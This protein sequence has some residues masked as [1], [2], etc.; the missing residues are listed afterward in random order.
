MKKQLMTATAAA[1]LA[2]AGA[3][4]TASAEIP[5][6]I[7]AGYGYWFFDRDVNGFDVDDT[8]TPVV[9]LE[10]AF[11]DNWAAEI[12]F[13]D[14]ETDLDGGP[15]ADVTT[16]QVGVLYYAGSYIGDGMRLRPYAAF[17]AGEIDIDA[18]TFDT[19]ETTVNGGLG[20][21][22]ML[23]KRVGVRLEAR[24]LYSLDESETD[25]LTTAG[26]NIYL[27]KVDADPVVQE[28]LDS[29]G[30]GVP[31]D[32]D[33]CPGTAPGT[34]VDADGCPLPVAK[35][36]SVKLKVN[37]DF[38][39]TKVKEQYFSDLGELADFLKRFSDLQVDVEGHTDSVGSDDYNLGLSQ[40]RA[41]AVVDVLVNQYG[42]ERSRLEPKGYGEAQPVASNDTK[43]G[44][45]EN[46]RV[47]ATLEVEYDD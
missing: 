20:V 23:G 16:W 30:D 43:E 6:T 35:V 39:S 29:D 17:G 21:R 9:G 25:I 32:R 26:L 34:R 37:F 3:A 42:I 13:A 18:D 8:G 5:V 28:V 12:L 11:N 27:G 44:R 38:D 40:R 45:A 7:N 47:M 1:C 19:V 14:D 4:Q 10:W 36:A 31:D 24:A 46:R 22:W 41:N 2:L 33:R 15:D